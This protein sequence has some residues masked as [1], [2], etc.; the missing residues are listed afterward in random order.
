MDIT[1]LEAKIEGYND[2]DSMYIVGLNDDLEDVT[3]YK[4]GL[5]DSIKNNSEISE[6]EYLAWSKMIAL[7]ILENFNWQQVIVFYW[8]KDVLSHVTMKVSEDGIL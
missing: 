8:F 5:L 2:R 4:Q 7:E 6:Q 1:T 3:I